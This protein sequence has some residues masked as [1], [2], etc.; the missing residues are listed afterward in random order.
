MEDTGESAASKAV[1]EKTKENA[2]Q[3]GGIGKPTDS[4]ASRLASVGESLYPNVRN[5][6]DVLRRI[7]VE[8]SITAE[9]PHTPN[10]EPILPSNVVRQWF[11]EVGFG[12]GRRG[13][14]HNVDTYFYLKS[15]NEIDNEGDI[16]QTI[17]TARHLTSL[18]AIHPESQWGVYKVGNGYQLF[19]VSPKLEP[20][21]LED[22]LSGEYDNLQNRPMLD[23]SH[24]LSWYK[25]IDPN[26]VP[27]KPIPESSVLHHLNWAEASNCDNWGWD[28]RGELFPIDVEVLHPSQ[29]S[30]KDGEPWKPRN[31]PS[32]LDETDLL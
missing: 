26:F 19:V 1:Q 29:P 21:S 7:T 30:F 18:G 14:Y 31:Y 16:D 17:A 13:T 32:R 12:N 10:G 4:S 9:I 15:C 27:G 8:S 3:T 24:L 6:M 2:K 25:R 11:N 28:R 5:V 23:N 20:W 22:Q